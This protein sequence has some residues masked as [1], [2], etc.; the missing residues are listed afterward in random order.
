MAGHPTSHACKRDE[1]KM[2]DY[3]DRRVTAPK[4]VISPNW[5]SP[6]PC[7]QA[8]ISDGVAVNFA[9]QCTLMLRACTRVDNEEQLTL[10]VQ[11]VY[12]YI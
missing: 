7:K 11:A 1:I 8:L 12:C 3:M 10:N 2:R 6:L 5:S 9:F 4:W